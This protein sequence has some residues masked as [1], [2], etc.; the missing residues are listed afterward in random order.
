MSKSIRV[1]VY[2]TSPLIREGLSSLLRTDAAIE[3]SFE[4]SSPKEILKKIRKNETD[5]LLIGLVRTDQKSLASLHRIRQS[6]PD[7]KLVVLDD[8]ARSNRVKEII[9]LGVRGF[10]CKLESSV[11]DIIRCIYEV[12]QGGTCLDFRV[13]DI[14]L[15][16]LHSEQVQAEQVLS[17]RECEVLD[18][19]STGKSNNE[20]AKNL[21]ISARTVKFHVSSILSK[22]NVKNRTEAAMTVNW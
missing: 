4:A 14:L 6:L 19:V 15:G 22:L 3:V 2:D 21:F 20:I 7:V 18:L 17:A 12:H 1:A 8:C 16:N 5:I 11:E 9:G 13:M 10:Q